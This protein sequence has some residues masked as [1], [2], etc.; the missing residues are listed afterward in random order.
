MCEGVDQRSSSII[1]GE[2]LPHKEP[3]ILDEQDGIDGRGDAFDEKDGDDPSRE[4][5]LPVAN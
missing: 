1:V 4:I 5:K 3:P 2:A